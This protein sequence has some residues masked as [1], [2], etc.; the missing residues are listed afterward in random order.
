[1]PLDPEGSAPGRGAAMPPD[2]FAAGLEAE[3]VR[4]LAHVVRS[5]VAAPRDDA[6]VS[7]LLLAALRDELESAEIAA[8]WMTAETELELKLALARQVGD[9]ARHYRLLADRLRQLGVDPDGV[10]PRARGYSHAYRYL[11][12]L[13]TPAER[14]AANAARGGV[15]RLRHAVAARLFEARGDEETAR[16]Y[17]EIIGPDEAWHLEFAKRT[18][19][20]YALTAD[21]Q[22]RARHA[23]ARTL[24]LV[25]DR[26][27]AVRTRGGGAAST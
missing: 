21:D 3:L 10:D 6:R 4:A 23:L 8:A 13:Q 19:A 16:I 7:E 12:G 9:E 15:A 17:R 2:E 5:D 14:L 26:P 27:E 11:K 20:R 1:M 22:E 24:Q 25:D 18:I